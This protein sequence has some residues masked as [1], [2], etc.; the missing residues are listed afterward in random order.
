[1]ANARRRFV[2]QTSGITGRPTL[3]NTT[4]L[5]SNPEPLIF[6]FA[7]CLSGSKLLFLFGGAASDRQANKE[8][9]HRRA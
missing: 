6:L 7:R 5:I 9:E 2:D 4:F 3:L 1:L 8:R